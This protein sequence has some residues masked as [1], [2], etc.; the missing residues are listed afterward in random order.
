MEQK[1]FEHIMTK[2]IRIGC[3]QTL[4]NLGLYEEYI[5]A[6]QAYKMYDTVNPDT[7][8]RSGGRKKVE[9]WRRKRWIV[10]YPSGNSQRAKYYYKRSELET[11]SLMLDIQNIIPPS[12]FGK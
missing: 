11:A 1:V 6:K 10:G 5:S 12:I 4:A 3:I 7:N 2:S 8:R 9:E